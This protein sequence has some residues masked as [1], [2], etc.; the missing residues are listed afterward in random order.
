MSPVPNRVRTVASV[1]V[2]LTLGA[3]VLSSCASAKVHVAHLEGTPALSIS[4]PLS[5]VGC[6]LNDVCL[7]VG[8][9]SE[10][11]G[12]TSVAE[13]STPKGRWLN[14]T[15]PTVRSPLFT[16]LACA[17]TACLLGGSEPGDDLLWR[18]VAVTHATSVLVPPTG[19]IGV[20]ALTCQHLN[21]SLIDT[22]AAGGALRFTSSI[23]G[24]VTWST[25]VDIP[26]A[27]GDAVTATSCGAPLN[28]VVSA[29]TSTHQLLLYATLDGGLT[30]TRR[31]TS[32]SWQSLSSLSCHLR[33]CVALVNDG[34]TSKLVRSVSFAKSWTSVSLAREADGLAC[35]T[36][37]CV[38]VGESS[39][40]VPWLATVHDDSVAH[41]TLRYV[42]TPLLGVACGSKVCAA[43]G[44]T[45]VLSVLNP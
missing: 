41:V 30:W 27:R 18:F 37:T 22:A 24:G 45:T 7:A 44:V 31:S 8:T 40:E 33:R 14:V 39:R 38:V 25:P 16:S 12:P 4:V 23:D 20:D 11:V 42:P 43:I 6:T 15:L 28:C 26:W 34:G 5:N 19:G 9:S 32:S 1:A 10:G 29:L 21:C 2:A 3:L 36:S 13:F 35:T 17:G